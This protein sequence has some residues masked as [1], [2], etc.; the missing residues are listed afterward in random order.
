M[1][2]VIEFICNTNKKIG[3]DVTNT[4]TIKIITN[5]YTKKDY[6]KYVDELW[7]IVFNDGYSNKDYIKF[8][9]NSNKFLKEHNENLNKIWILSINQFLEELDYS[10]DLQLKNKIHS[11][12]ACTFE[13]KE[14]YIDRLKHKL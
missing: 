8:N 9:E 14:Q 12:Q 2:N 13:T 7:I 10:I 5:K 1:G 6:Y 11:Y 3:I 4:K